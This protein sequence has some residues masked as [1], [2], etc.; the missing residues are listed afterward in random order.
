M[1]LFVGGCDAVL[2]YCG[3]RGICLDG[4]SP[5]NIHCQ[6][7]ADFVGRQCELSGKVLLDRTDEYC[8]HVSLLLYM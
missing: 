1:S 2:D 4:D 6:C 5:R 8:N 3:G 7:E